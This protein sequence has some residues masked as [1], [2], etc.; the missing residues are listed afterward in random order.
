MARHEATLETLIKPAAAAG[1]RFE[2]AAAE[3]LAW[4]H[5]RG[6]RS[7]DGSVRERPTL[8]TPVAASPLTADQL[9]AEAV[10]AEASIGP[11]FRFVAGAALSP[12]LPLSAGSGSRG[13]GKAEGAPQSESG[14]ATIP[15]LSPAPRRSQS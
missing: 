15:E 13:G 3:L 5:R 12:T 9:T 11:R 10:E 4:Q 1:R 2:P 8:C 7:R 6:T 14:G